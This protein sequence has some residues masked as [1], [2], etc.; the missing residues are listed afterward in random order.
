MK[1]IEVKE[2]I[3]H[4]T[5]HNQEDYICLTDM[6]KHKDIMVLY[7]MVKHKSTVVLGV[8]EKIYNQI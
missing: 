4:I 7:L 2:T 8:W 5:Q 3:I 6:L 1:L